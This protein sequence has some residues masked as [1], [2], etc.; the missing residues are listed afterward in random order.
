MKTNPARF[1]Q[2]N[3]FSLVELMIAVVIGLLSTLVIMQ[4]FTAFEGQKRTT[5]GSSD[6]QTNGA[7]AL[8]SIERELMMAGYGL[9]LFS[10]KDSPMKCYPTTFTVDH[11]NLPTTP[12]IGFEPIQITDGGANGESDTVTIRYSSSAVASASGGVPMNIGGVSV[13]DI[14]VDVALGCNDKDVAMLINGSACSMTLVAGTPTPIVGPPKKDKVTVAS[15]TNAVVGGTLAC[16]GRWSEVSY[17][18][19][20]QDNRY[21]LE[22]VDSRSTTFPAAQPRQSE[23]VNIQ[24]Q[25]GISTTAKDFAV[26]EWVDA[27]DPWDA[28]FLSDRNRI[29]AVRIAVVAR[30]GLAEKEKVTTACGS[31]FCAEWEDPVRPGLTRNSPAMK[32]AIPG[33]DWENYRYRTYQTIVPLR[34][35]IWASPS[36]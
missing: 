30:S 5:S 31:Q 11:D 7:L 12:S 27:V 4:T 21:W 19:G 10:S 25:Y 14:T 15:A 3:G 8:Y 29:K 32:V 13:T 9:P 18:V 16:L 23:I 6:A 34:N 36:L 17:R 22:T 24:A 28:P 35:L 26:S 2:Q 33:A 20:H 1:V